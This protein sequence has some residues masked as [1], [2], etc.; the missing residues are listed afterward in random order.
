MS[1]V[2]NPFT[3]ELDYY[4]A[5]GAGAET[6][7]LSLHLDQ[8]TPQTVLGGQPIFQGGIATQA[9]SDFHDDIKAYFNIQFVEDE[10]NPEIISI[11]NLGATESYRMGLP[12]EKGTAGQ[13]LA[14]GAVDGD[15]IYLT[16]AD[17]SSTEETDPVFAEWLETNPLDDFLKL[18]QGDPQTVT[19]TP[20]FDDSIQINDTITSFQN[21]EVRTMIDFDN[22]QIL[23]G[24]G[25]ISIDFLNRV[26][27]EAVYGATAFNWQTQ[28][29]YTTD[30][31]V[32]TVETFKFLDWALRFRQRTST[33]D[34][35]SAGYNKLYFKNDGKLYTLNSAG[36]EAEVGAGGGYTDLTEFVDQTAWRIFYSDGDRDVIEL[37]LG[38]VGKVLTSN[39]ASSAPTFETPTPNTDELVK[40][41][42]DDTAAGYLGAKTVAGTGISLAE[43]TGGNADK[44]EITNSDTGSDAVSAHEL[45]YDHSD[46]HDA[47]TVTDTDTINMSITGQQIS[48]DVN[49]QMSIT[50]DASGIKLSGDSATP[51]NTKL[52]GTNGSGTKGWYDQP[53]GSTY[54]ETDYIGITIDNGASAITAG[55]KGYF[56]VPYAGTIKSWYLTADT[57][58]SIVVDIW[59]AAGTIP[60]VANTITA[61]A[62]PT[63]TSAQIGNSSTLTGWTTSVSAGDVVAYNV[64]SAT[65]IRKVTLIVKIEKS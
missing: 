50:S 54:T 32:G 52:Y 58:G 7:P 11:A 2:F 16:F 3:S 57:S 56:T 23:D 8:T 27:R 40:Y 65:T 21:G 25:N 9:V 36:S 28:T 1:W 18:D 6:D 22:K 45:A 63:L 49:V 19:G 41:A 48:G 38:D 30:L 44:L 37:A 14:I 17:A 4:E 61:S 29:F 64:D 12:S 10:L 31:D 59:K 39:G 20:V 46:L 24:L 62:K 53:T 34:N 47:A 15:D 51:G 5:G 13:V 26:L 35:P 33:P 60:T 55:L 43:G 42:A